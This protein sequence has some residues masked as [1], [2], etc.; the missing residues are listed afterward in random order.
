MCRRERRKKAEHL[1][2]WSNHYYINVYRVPTIR[3]VPRKVGNNQ[4]VTP[5]IQIKTIT[6]HLPD[7]LDLSVNEFLSGIMH[8]MVKDVKLSVTYNQEGFYTNYIAMIIYVA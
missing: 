2:R 8:S 6:E 1:E 4:E 7:K 5:M 3:Y